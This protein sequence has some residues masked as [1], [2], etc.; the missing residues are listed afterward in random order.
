MP[1]EI[2]PDIEVRHDTRFGKPV[3]KGTRVPVG[4]VVGKIAGGM[5]VQEVAQEYDLTREQ[6]FV[7]LQYAAKLVA[8]EELAVGA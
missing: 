6:V 3:I 8:E 5:T 2:F 1:N 4:L 7:A